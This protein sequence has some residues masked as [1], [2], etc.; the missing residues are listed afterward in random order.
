MSWSSKDHVWNISKYTDLRFPSNNPIV[1]EHDLVLSIQKSAKLLVLAHGNRKL[2]Q[3][4][5]REPYPVIKFRDLSFYVSLRIHDR[6]IRFR[7]RAMSMKDS[8]DITNVISQFTN[9]QQHVSK[10]RGNSRTNS[11]SPFSQE[12]FKHSPNDSYDAFGS[13]SSNDSMSS[14]R[15][16]ESATPPH[17]NS[18]G[19][20]YGGLSDVTPSNSYRETIDCGSQTD[21]VPSYAS[22]NAIELEEHLRKLLDSPSFQNLLSNTKTALNRIKGTDLSR[23]I[24]KGRRRGKMASTRSSSQAE[25]I[26]QRF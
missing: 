20:D 25:S 3:V 15:Y 2:H 13:V 4:P 7:F 12:A 22:M 1:L 8:R 5:L 17:R 26:M 6:D 18:Y 16:T 9:V 10:N 21:Q 11:N 19:G 24:T 23:V 14:P